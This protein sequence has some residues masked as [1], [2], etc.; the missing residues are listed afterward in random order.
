VGREVAGVALWEADEEV[1]E[2]LQEEEVASAPVAEVEEVAEASQEVGAVVSPL[3]AGQVWGEDLHADVVDTLP[4]CALVYTLA[5]SDRF[6][7]YYSCQWRLLQLN[8]KRFKSS[9]FGRFSF[10]VS[11]RLGF[12]T[13]LSNIWAEIKTVLRIK[14]GNAQGYA[15]PRLSVMS[16]Q[17]QA[18][19]STWICLIRESDFR[20]TTKSEIYDTLLGQNGE[21][22]CVKRNIWDIV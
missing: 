7:W 16:Q 2:V 13:I 1:E 12:S 17:I 20:S 6:V 18:V 14:G 8:L 19:K 5:F 21:W 11:L 9:A 4:N 3:E 22:S 15:Q 10:N